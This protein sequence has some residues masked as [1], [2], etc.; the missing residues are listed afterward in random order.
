MNH[1]YC[2]ACSETTEKPGTVDLAPGEE[3]FTCPHCKTEWVIRVEFYEPIRNVKAREK[4]ELEELLE[5]MR[6]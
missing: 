5:R 4:R 1:Y 6:Q 2:P 3:S